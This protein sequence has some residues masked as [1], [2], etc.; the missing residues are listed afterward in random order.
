MCSEPM[1]VGSR[2]R[3]QHQP[4]IIAQKGWQVE[5]E[6]ALL[7]CTGMKR[8]GG[9]DLRGMVRCDGWGARSSVRVRAVQCS[10]KSMPNLAE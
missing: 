4:E 5:L 1:V 8:T 7:Y 2:A 6:R 10:A 9:T 3:A